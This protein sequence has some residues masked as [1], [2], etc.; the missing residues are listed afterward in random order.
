MTSRFRFFSWAKAVVQSNVPVSS[1]RMQVSRF[2]TVSG[3]KS[4]TA[5]WP[6]RLLLTAS[7]FSSS[8]VRTIF[9]PEDARGNLIQI[10]TTK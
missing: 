8:T 9:L 6:V 5:R 7:R 2:M 4:Q 1:A 10:A 3:C